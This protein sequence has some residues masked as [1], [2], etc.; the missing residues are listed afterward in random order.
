MKRKEFK[1]KNKKKPQLETF[2]FQNLISFFFFVRLA[3][4]SGRSNV[5][6]GTVT[7]SAQ[8]GG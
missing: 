5:I 3:A 2:V 6:A 8:S 7:R 1:K 4:E